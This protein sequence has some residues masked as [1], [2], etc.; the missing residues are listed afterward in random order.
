[1]RV[2]RASGRSMQEAILEAA[3]EL[4]AAEGYDAVSM[5]AIAAQAGV[6]KGNL[7]HHF[8][9]K[10]ELHVSVMRDACE[11]SATALDRILDGDGSL[12]TRMGAYIREHLAVLEAEPENARLVLREVLQA[13]PGRGQALAERVFGDNFRK[14][15]DLFR[16]GQASGELAADIDPGLVAFVLLSANTM[17]FQSRYVIRHLPDAEFARDPERYA[18]L[19]MGLLRHGVLACP[20]RSAGA[21]HGDPEPDPT[22]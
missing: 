12:A 5:N 2:D 11:H 10:E 13:T 19:L 17:L 22:H 8:G 20:E 15:A 3:R 14:L 18:Q 9:S 4:F 21:G 1:M 16:A 6:S 7:F